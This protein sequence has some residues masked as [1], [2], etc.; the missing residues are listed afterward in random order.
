VDPT[1]GNILTVKKM[2]KAHHNIK[3]VSKLSDAEYSQFINEVT[4]TLASEFGFELES[5]KN[6]EMKDFLRLVYSNKD[7]D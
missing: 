2:L 7:W 5:E 4:V 1:S 6:I 3:R